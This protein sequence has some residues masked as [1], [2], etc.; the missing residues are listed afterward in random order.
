MKSLS[1]GELKK[2]V[3]GIAGGGNQG[4]DPIEKPKQPTLK[5][6]SKNPVYIEPNLPKNGG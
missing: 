1:E 3:G 5:R 2:V 6:S 4:G